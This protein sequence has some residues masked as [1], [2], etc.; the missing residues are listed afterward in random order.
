MSFKTN[1]YRTWIIV[2][3][4][5]AILFELYFLFVYQINNAVSF[6]QL[7]VQIDTLIPAAFVYF[8]KWTNGLKLENIYVKRKTELDNFKDEVGEVRR[9]VNDLI[10][11]IKYQN[12]E[13]NYA[14]KYKKIL[15]KAS[16]M[17]IPYNVSRDSSVAEFLHLEIDNSTKYSTEFI[18]NSL[19]QSI[20]SFQKLNGLIYEESK[21]LDEE[22]KSNDSLD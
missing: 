12:G 18:N 13:M 4:I 21:K 2:F 9:E 11:S 16:K 8:I 10:S 17:L 1:K 6:I 19:R 22:Y 7:C 14:E 15:K 3:E 20:S 5:I